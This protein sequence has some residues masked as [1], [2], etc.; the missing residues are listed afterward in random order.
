LVEV[1]ATKFKQSAMGESSWFNH[2]FVS[3][4]GSVDEKTTA[5]ATVALFA[6]NDSPTDAEANLRA[7]LISQCC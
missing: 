2:I 7:H 5:R 6:E 4:D 3:A 1:N